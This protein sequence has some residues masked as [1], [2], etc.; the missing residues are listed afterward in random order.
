M[1]IARFREMHNALYLWYLKNFKR[2]LRQSC[3]RVVC[4]PSY[5]LYGAFSVPLPKTVELIRWLSHSPLRRSSLGLSRNFRQRLRDK[6][7]ERSGRARKIGIRGEGEEANNS[8][9]PNAKNSFARPKF[10]SYGNAWY[11]GC[12]ASYLLMSWAPVR[13][14]LVSHYIFICLF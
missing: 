1:S 6:P 11:A 4:T 14:S 10:A 7:T 2:T 12:G 13:P 3:G 5:G 8:R 9:G